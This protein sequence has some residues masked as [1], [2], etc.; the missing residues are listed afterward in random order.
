MEIER[1]REEKGREGREEIESRRE[2]AYTLF[3]IKHTK[4][5]CYKALRISKNCLFKKAKNSCLVSGVMT[6]SLYML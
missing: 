4:G 3:S 5:C 6:F 1:E 2:D